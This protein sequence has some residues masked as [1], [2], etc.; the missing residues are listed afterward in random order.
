MC[1]CVCVYSSSNLIENPNT[2]GKYSAAS[3]DVVTKFNE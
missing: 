1:V 2:I 3:V